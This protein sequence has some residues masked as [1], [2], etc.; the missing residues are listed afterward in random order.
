SSAVERAYNWPH[1]PSELVSEIAGEI[2]R[3]ESEIRI[4]PA[5]SKYGSPFLEWLGDA[6][7]GDN[8]ADIFDAHGLIVHAEP[9]IILGDPKVGKTLLVE[10]LALHLAAGRR[11]W[12]GVPLYRRC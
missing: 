7:P 3:F 2:G 4:G 9:S 10:D 12:C 1:D 11:E 5:G 8:P 6:E